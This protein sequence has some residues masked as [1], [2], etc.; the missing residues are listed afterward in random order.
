[1]KI[2]QIN[3]SQSFKSRNSTIRFADDIS[4]K[5]NTIFPHYST[6]RFSDFQNYNNFKTLDDSL[7][8]K[9]TKLRVTIAGRCLFANNPFE[10]IM[11]VIDPVKEQKIANCFE[12]SELSALVAKVNGIENFK[13]AIAVGKDHAILL[14]DDKKHPYIIDSWL[15]FADYKEKAIERFNKDFSQHFNSSSFYFQEIPEDI[16]IMKA[17]NKFSTKELQEKFP[18]LIIK[19]NRRNV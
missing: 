10:K 19:N 14:V 3:S 7:F 15:G 17:L 8:K 4:R 1:M 11:A 9:L 13:I 18:M 12:C 5:V 2:R 16:T 6:S